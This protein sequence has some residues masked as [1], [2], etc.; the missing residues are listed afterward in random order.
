M[1]VD[2]KPSFLT[3]FTRTDRQFITL[4]PTARQ[5]NLY[6]G[7]I[8]ELCSCDVMKKENPGLDCII[9]Y[10][11]TQIMNAALEVCLLFI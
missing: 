8:Q 6:S 3:F 2:G 9:I 1:S 7:I 11:D 10:G 5:H 4:K